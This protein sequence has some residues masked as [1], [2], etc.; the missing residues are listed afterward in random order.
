M[1]SMLFAALFATTAG[2]ALAAPTAQDR[3]LGE[4]AAGVR[5][6]RMKADVVKLV[7]FGTRH[8]LSSQT[9]P[10]RG[11]GASLR[12]SAAELR[13]LG[14]EMAT[15]SDVVTG[16]RVPNPTKITDVLGIQ[17]GTERPN[18]VVI[19][20]GHIDSRVTDVMNFTD[21]ADRLGDL[22]DVADR[23]LLDHADRLVVNDVHQRGPCLA[24]NLEIFAFIIAEL[25]FLD[26]VAGDHLGNVGLGHRPH[27]RADQCIDLGLR[28]VGDLGLRRPRAG[29]QS[30]DFLGFGRLFDSDGGS[31]GKKLLWK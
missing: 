26:G 6:A 4:I 28:I 3:R 24:K 11:I 9:D 25:G 16:R 13:K 10:K 18:D 1:R 15:P 2:A 23:I 8:T 12:W 30:G 19:I 29:H 7:S 17:R 27:H 21:D 31:H 20:Q 5:A 22:D 14:L